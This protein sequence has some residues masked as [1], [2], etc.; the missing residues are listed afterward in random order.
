[1]LLVSTINGFPEL[2]AGTPTPRTA[3][4]LFSGYANVDDIEI[5]HKDTHAFYRMFNLVTNFEKMN[6]M[7]YIQYALVRA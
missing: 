7:D 3:A 1:M 4:D 5:Y 6:N 2:P